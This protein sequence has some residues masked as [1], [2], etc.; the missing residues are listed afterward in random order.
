MENVIVKRCCF[1]ELIIVEDD[2]D[3]DSFGDFNLMN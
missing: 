2:Y 3:D 1:L